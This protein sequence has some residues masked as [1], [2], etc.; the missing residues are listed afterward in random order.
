MSRPLR[1]EFP[2]ALYHI[3]CRG[4]RREAIYLDD[5]DR[6]AHLQVLADALDR[7]DAQALAYCLMGNHYHVVL[8]THRANLSRLM[9]HVN[10]VYSQR[11][12]RQHGLVG[13]L[14]QGRYKAILVDRDAYLWALCRYVERNPVAARMVAHVDD[15]AWSSYRAHVGLALPPPWLDV[16]GLHSFILGCPARSPAHRR[17]AAALY[18]E[19]VATPCDFAPWQP[20]LRR[21]VFLGDDAFIERSLKHCEVRAA[22]PDGIPRQQTLAPRTL[23]SILAA[24]TALAQGMRSAYREGGFTMSAIARHAGLSV[25]SVSRMIAAAD[26]GSSAKLKT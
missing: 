15:W 10:G 7:F 18:A 19:S 26:G 6:T 17:R 20:G 5:A 9:R 4:D 12:N 13:H 11:F 8:Q 22:D 23:P 2:G 21:Q 16:E 25:S 1:L 24:H 14:F 3:T